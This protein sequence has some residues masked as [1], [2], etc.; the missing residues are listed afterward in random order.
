MQVMLGYGLATLVLALFMFSSTATAG[1]IPVHYLGYLGVIPISLGTWRFWQLFR[2]HSTHVV[3][4][5]VTTGGIYSI[6]LTQLANSGDTIATFLP[7]FFE[8]SAYHAVILLA[9]FIGMATIWLWIATLLITHRSVA[10]SLERYGHYL[11]PVFMIGIGLYILMNT[12]TDI[13]PG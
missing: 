2:A 1:L 8:S 12:Q 4:A 11:A 6:V 10:V 5:V 3:N 9:T 13:V 7:A